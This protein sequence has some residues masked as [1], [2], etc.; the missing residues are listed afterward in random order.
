MSTNNTSRDV[1]C[2]PN[3]SVGSQSTEEKPKGPHGRRVGVCWY[4]FNHPEKENPDTV[5]CYY[6]KK[7]I[8]WNKTGSGSLNQHVTKHHQKELEDILKDKKNTLPLIQ[9]DIQERMQHIKSTGFQQG[10]SESLFVDFIIDNDQA[11]LVGI[12]RP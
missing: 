3:H 5:R 10:I 11:F 6:C 4:F 1:E 8:T 2:N 9:S 12:M 7:N